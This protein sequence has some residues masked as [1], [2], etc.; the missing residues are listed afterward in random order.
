MF[1]S[2]TIDLSSPSFVVVQIRDRVGEFGSIQRRIKIPPAMDFYRR[3]QNQ[4][5]L[6]KNLGSQKRPDVKNDSPKRDEVRHSSTI[7]AYS[8]SYVVMVLMI[9]RSSFHLW[10]L[11]IAVPSRF[12]RFHS[13]TLETPL[14]A[15]QLHGQK[16]LFENLCVYKTG[17][18]RVV[19][20]VPNNR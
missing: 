4:H 1:A 8:S 2:E 5:A 9:L 18:I 7:S 14:I 16:S 3:S 11:R 19:L 6:T 12:V 10:N 20:P 15:A 17:W 13:G